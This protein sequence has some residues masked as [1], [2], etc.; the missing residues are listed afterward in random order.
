[1]HSP[2]FFIL[3]NAEI[4]SNPG[5]KHVIKG[6]IKEDEKLIIQSLIRLIWLLWKTTQK[7]PK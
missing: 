4:R 5:N 2:S 7:Q 3:F 6:I 1:M